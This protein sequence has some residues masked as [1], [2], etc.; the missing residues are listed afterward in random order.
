MKVWK[1]WGCGFCDIFDFVGVEVGGF[2]DGECVLE[3]DLSIIFWKL[4]FEIFVVCDNKFNLI[5][6]MIKK[7]G[8]FIIGLFIF[9]FCVFYDMWLYIFCFVVD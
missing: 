8:N 9:G 4:S 1:V 5:W 3:G 7:F 2:I 6:F